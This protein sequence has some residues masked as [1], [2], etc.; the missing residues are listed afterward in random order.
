MTPCQT[1]A[2]RIFLPLCCF[3]AGGLVGALIH[4]LYFG[5]CTPPPVLFCAILFRSLFL[6]PFCCLLASSGMFT[7]GSFHIRMMALRRHG[8]QTSSAS[9]R[10]PEQYFYHVGVT[11]HH[12]VCG[13]AGRVCRPPA[14]SHNTVQGQ[15]LYG[16]I[17]VR[18]AV[19]RHLLLYI[20]IYDY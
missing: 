2:H 12:P 8:L 19:G 6:S 15:S 3:N 1:T 16:V 18:R 10:S 9:L 5:G 11:S 20:Y 14:L 7:L 13:L 4:P 17:S